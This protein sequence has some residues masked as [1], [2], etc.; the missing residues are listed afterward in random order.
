MV[1]V[2]LGSHTIECSDNPRLLFHIAQLSRC[3]HSIVQSS[4][5]AYKAF[6]KQLF[7][8]Q[9]GNRSVPRHANLSASIRTAVR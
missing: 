7:T 8:I 9:S 6:A 5:L 1:V 4:N 3:M 2:L